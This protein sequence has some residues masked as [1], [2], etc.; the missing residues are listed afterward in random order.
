MIFSQKTSTPWPFPFFRRHLSDL[1][2]EARRG[3]GSMMRVMTERYTVSK[4]MR[5]S[6]FNSSEIEVKS[7]RETLRVFSE[8]K[9]V[10]IIKVDA[11][12]IVVSLYIYIYI[13]TYDGSYTQNS[14]Y[15]YIILISLY[16]LISIHVH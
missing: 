6:C 3:P 12:V 13:Y 14:I 15:Q 2:G 10:G 5:S 7:W 16:I 11:P 8:W 9:G 1:P 4:R